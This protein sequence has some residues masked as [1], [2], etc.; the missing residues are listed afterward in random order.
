MQ[1][2]KFLPLRR[3]PIIP[4][5]LLF[6]CCSLQTLAQEEKIDHDTTY[7]ISLADQMLTRFYFSRKYTNLELGAPRG[8][9]RLRYKP[10]TTLNMGVG[11]TYR[12]LTLNLAY[13]FPFLNRNE[14]KGKTKY[15]D[16][17]SHIYT[18][19]WSYDFWGQFYK[20]YYMKRS[21][22]DGGSGYYLRPDMGVT[23]LGIS[24]Y[25]I[26]GHERFSYRAAF[27]QNERQL[28]SAGSW[29]LGAEIYY[30]RATADSALVPGA[31]K[32][33]F[34]QR[35]VERVRFLDIGP[36]AGYAYNWVIHNDFFLGMAAT[37]NL[38]I[39]FVR[40]ITPADSRE[41]L[42]FSPNFIYRA[43]GGYNSERWMASLSLVGNRVSARGPS[44]SYN[45]SFSTGNYRATLA[46]RFK[47]GRKL[48]K[49]LAPVD[50]LLN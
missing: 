22:I 1:H 9:D 3:K 19:K 20:G 41:R 24:A 29:L 6:L 44:S 35:E 7:Y 50:K 42:G 40:E 8:E 17:Q 5:F 39:G 32:D 36:G 47:P 30:G 12:S 21:A 11:A 34:D 43:T 23:L 28:K 14:E 25:N 46:Y 2:L 4:A 15:L 13:G 27:V 10:N 48:K 37:I 31:L 49:Y 33:R 38:N 26:V 45:Y 18:R 16:L